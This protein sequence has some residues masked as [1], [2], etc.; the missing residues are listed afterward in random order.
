ME[1][2]TRRQAK[3]IPS[4]ILTGTAKDNSG[5]LC[6]DIQIHSMHN[7]I[8][9]YIR[10]MHVCFSPR[11]VGHVSLHLSPFYS[12]WCHRSAKSGGVVC[13]RIQDRSS[14]NFAVWSRL[15]QL[16]WA[17]ERAGL[18]GT[19]GCPFCLYCTQQLDLSRE[20]APRTVLF[21]RGSEGGCW[22][23]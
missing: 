2:W 20:P 1:R 22:N 21:L 10:Y 14:F 12:C 3:I 18:V 7:H 9:V 16:P 19:F 6:Y 17:W 8:Y 11:N 15:V 4:T 23:G 5:T 13:I